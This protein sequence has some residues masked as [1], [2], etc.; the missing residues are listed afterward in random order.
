MIGTLALPFG[1]FPGLH[2]VLILAPIL[3]RRHHLTAFEKYSEERAVRVVDVS[4]VGVGVS[5]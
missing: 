3:L 1:R 5:T 2:T 4:S